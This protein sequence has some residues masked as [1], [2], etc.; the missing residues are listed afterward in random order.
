MLTPTQQKAKA[1]ML[2]GED[3]FLT[4]AAGSG[5]S[6]LI[7][8]FCEDSAKS[9]ALLGT[10]GLGASVI[11]GRTVHSYFGLGIKEYS[12]QTL[13]NKIRDNTSIKEDVVIIDEVS[14][15]PANLFTPI[16]QVLKERGKQ[17]ICVGDFYQLPPVKGDFAFNSPEWDLGFY[18][19]EGSQRSDDELLNTALNKIRKGDYPEE[20]LKDCLKE[21]PSDK[22]IPVLFPHNKAVDNLNQERLAKL[23]G[24]AV[25]FMH[26]YETRTEPRIMADSPFCFKR[27]ALV[28][29]TANDPYGEYFNGSCGN[30]V[31]W[32]ESSVKV[33][34]LTG[35]KVWVKQ[36]KRE[37]QMKADGSWKTFKN[38]YMPMKLAWALTIHKSQGQSYD[39][40]VMD[41]RDLF[42]P[43]QGYVALSRLRS[44]EGIYLKGFDKTSCLVSEEVKQ[45]MKTKIKEV[46]NG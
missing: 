5:K 8:D 26:E 44:K 6:Y 23:P 15:L 46:K 45:W 13:L 40:A 37:Y 29:I 24:T 42:A 9:I 7:N 33:R 11:G 14:M 10:T 25:Q 30:V 17:L 22:E 16:R 36:V 35:D 41:L 32:T 38:R 21:P 4:G 12:E 3:L 18:F 31:D 19:L 28:M 34:L 2:F 39:M 43:G 20:F 27:D 1:A